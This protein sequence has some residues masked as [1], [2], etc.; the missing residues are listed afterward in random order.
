MLKILDGMRNAD[1]FSSFS[2]KRVAQLGMHTY[3][4]IVK[5]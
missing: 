3:I 2:R 4:V 5:Q 1:I